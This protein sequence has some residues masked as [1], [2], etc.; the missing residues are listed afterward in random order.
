MRIVI[1]LTVISVFCANLFAYWE[2]TP[3]TGKW[4]NPKYAVKDT[5]VE[6]WQYAESFRISGNN[7]SAIR[8]YNKLVKHF[9]LSPYAPKSLFEMAKIYSK[10]G[11]KD[12]AF[13]KLDEIVKR[14][15]DFAEIENVLKM[16]R[17]ISVEILQKKQLR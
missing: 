2:W 12:A 9:P 15:P 16:Q 5:D 6:Q 13:N 7:E 14:Y 11:D 1:L 17:E 3:K 10:S 4:I 8:E